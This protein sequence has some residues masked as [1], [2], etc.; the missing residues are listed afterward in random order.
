MH[1]GPLQSQVH[2]NWMS[3]EANVQKHEVDS[4]VNK[5]K[6]IGRKSKLKF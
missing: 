3:L 4:S 5:N 2:L 1:N 6:V